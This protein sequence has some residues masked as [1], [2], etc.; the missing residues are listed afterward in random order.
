MADPCQREPTPAR[1][2][3]IP[4]KRLSDAD[5]KQIE[6]LAAVC[7]QVEGGNLPLYLEPPADDETRTFLYY[8]R[9]MLVGVAVAPP[10]DPIEVVSIVHPEHRC[11]G[12]GRA[13]VGAVQQ[14]ARR[15]GVSS[16]LLV[17]ERAVPSGAAFA[18]AVGAEHQFSEYR[19]ELA[20][21]AFAKRRPP[22]RTLELRQ[23]D[24][25]DVD[26]LVDLWIAS[27]DIAEDKARETTLHWLG[28]E[29][30]RLVIGRL[31]DEPVGML[32]LHLEPSSVFINSFRVH[33]RHRGRGY[34]RQILMGVIEQLL[35]ED[36]GY[37]LIEV[38]TD[39]TVA[40]S[41][42][43]SCGFQRVAEYS[44]YELSV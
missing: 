2:G 16:L 15:R 33:P 24:M 30:Q 20:P 28:Q 44:Y 35:T 5:R 10:D 39:N 40:L 37:I 6:A 13:L 34:G 1:Q 9:G 7:K 4:V 19:M 17:C 26:A 36:W 3:L 8:R 43:E 29:N 21:V 27:R 22:R 41:L 18:R 12:I 25:R 38:A 31:R 42:Y 32:R 14:E 11:Q 23:A